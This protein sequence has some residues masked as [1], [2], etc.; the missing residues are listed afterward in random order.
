[1]KKVL[2]TGSGT[3]L[4]HE[5]AIRTFQKSQPTG[6]MQSSKTPNNQHERKTKNRS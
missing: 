1:M 4:G 6:A 5:M 3:G 2:I